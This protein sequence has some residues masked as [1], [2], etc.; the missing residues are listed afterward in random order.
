MPYFPPP[1]PPTFLRLVPASLLGF[2][3]YDLIAIAISISIAINIIIVIFFSTL[4]T[5][6]AVIIVYLPDTFQLLPL[7]FSVF[8]FV[9]GLFT[10]PYALLIQLQN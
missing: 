1:S 9:K 5:A 10:S 8:A 4:T 6:I 3:L 2:S 7:P